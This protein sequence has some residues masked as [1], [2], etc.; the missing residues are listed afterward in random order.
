M[1]YQS[2]LNWVTSE[3]LIDE[4]A[5][6]P[7]AKPAAAASAQAVQAATSQAAAGS[8]AGPGAG[9][10]PAHGRAGMSQELAARQGKQ[11]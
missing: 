10:L 7:S 4:L 5:R 3:T 9:L 8:T 11:E 2:D 1:Q 6:M